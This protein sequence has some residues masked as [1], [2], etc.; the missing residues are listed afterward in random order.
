VPATSNAQLRPSRAGR[1]RLPALIL[2]TLA[3]IPA[4]LVSSSPSVAQRRE[5]LFQQFSSCPK[6]LGYVRS[7]ALPLV[8]PYGFRDPNVPLPASP[9]PG[10]PRP[11]PKLT[12]QKVSAPAGAAT[13]AAP[14]TPVPEAAPETAAAAASAEPTADQNARANSSTTNTQEVNVDE[15]DLIENDG[16]YLYTG[17]NGSVRIVDT[18]NGTLVATIPGEPGYEPQLLLDGPI[19]AVVRQINAQWPETVV[20]RWN[21]SNPS[22]PTLFSKVHLEGTLLAARSVDHKAR[23]VL[24]TPFGSRLTFVTPKGNTR[25]GELSALKANQRIV[26]RATAN[27]WLP[28]AYD[29]DQNGTAT[30]LR[31]A[32]NCVEIGKPADTTG[33]GLT[34]A[35]TIDLNVP[36]PRGSSSGSGGVVGNS[37]IVYASDYTLFVATTATTVSSTPTPVTQTVKTG[38]GGGVIVRVPPTV[39]R[40]RT[41][42]LIHAFDLKVPDGITYLASGQVDGY[43]LNQFAMSEYGGALRV[44]VTTDSE[45]FGA[46]QQSGVRVMARNGRDIEQIGTLNGLGISERIYG[47][48]FLAELGYIVTFRQTDPLYVIDLRDPRAPRRAGELKIPG[49]SAYL[50]PIGPGRLLGVGQDATDQGRRLGTALQ[51]FDI[52]DPANPKQLSKLRVGGQSEAEYDHRA[53]LWWG[54]SR[55]A[56]IP[57]QT[58]EEGKPF[59]GAVVTQVNDGAITMQGMVRHQRTDIAEIPVTTKDGFMTPVDNAAPPT[60]AL[61]ASRPAPVQYIPDDAIRRS[62]IVNGRLVTVSQNAVKVTDLSTVSP[63][64]YSTFF[65]Q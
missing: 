64:F 21:V 62:A 31:Q 56:V 27:D 23:I 26:N 30:P 34:W 35:T 2:T 17:A 57:Q 4:G 61:A 3:V 50:H 40:S 60:T 39:P 37:S 58:F 25:N 42:T 46:P 32:V 1:R 47:V 48:R 8:T 51:V 38:F 14:A 7:I 43:L 12:K 41:R 55:N 33:L 18:T 44:A 13:T 54:P 9:V 28:R 29:T 20:E 53:F 22:R 11:R 45:G 63:L 24:Q 10:S 65:D 5:V 16:R 52:S 36:N 49:Y 6:F 59:S 15:G 19:L